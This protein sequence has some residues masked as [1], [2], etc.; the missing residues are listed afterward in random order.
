VDL[1]DTRTEVPAPISTTNDPQIPL[2]RLNKR[3]DHGVHTVT[4]ELRYAA[5][6][7][8][9]CAHHA[10][11]RVPGNRL[12]HR[13]DNRNHSGGGVDTQSAEAQNIAG[14]H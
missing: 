12:V 8:V 10:S 7:R 9:S 1:A 6:R 11:K 2:T 3:S 5:H 4:D 14:S 13:L